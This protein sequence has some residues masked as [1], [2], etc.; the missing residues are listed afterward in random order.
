MISL[1]AAN[2]RGLEN[3]GW[4]NS[5]HSFS[6]GQY[7]DPEHTGYSVLKVINDDIVIPGAG[8]DTHSHQNMEII[9]YVLSGAIEHRDSE[10]NRLILPAGEFQLM[11]AGTGIYHSEHNASQQHS[12]RFLQIWISPDVIDTPPGYQQKGFDRNEGLTTV[13]SPDGRDGSLEIKQDVFIHRLI[14]SPGA[15]LSREIDQSRKLY[16][17]QVRGNL[18]LP[19]AI[20]YPGDGLKIERQYDLDIVNN[21][22][23]EAEML[24]FDLP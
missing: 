10:G 9:S 1:R 13:V 6:F 5:R 22:D 21:T 16:L 3:F 14:L 23:Q 12:L 18:M 4:L 2:E 11:S 24:L 15:L 17:H 19:E 20:L 7:R 8:F